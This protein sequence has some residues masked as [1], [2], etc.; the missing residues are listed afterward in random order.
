M[1]FLKLFFIPFLLLTF[2]S[3]KK[4]E[5]NPNKNNSSVEDL[6]LAHTWKMQEL[7]VQ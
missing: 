1:N 6:L 2:L 3:C 4:T 5:V 7:R